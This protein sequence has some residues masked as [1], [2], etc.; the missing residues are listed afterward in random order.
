MNASRQQPSEPKRE[1][2]SSDGERQPPTNAASA[3]PAQI[4]TPASNGPAAASDAA[5]VAV[6]EVLAPLS[7]AIAEPSTER[8]RSP[9]TRADQLCDSEKTP[10]RKNEISPER[11][12]RHKHKHKGHSIEKKHKNSQLFEGWDTTQ[13]AQWLSSIGLYDIIPEEYGLTTFYYRLVVQIQLKIFL[14]LFQNTTITSSH[15]NIVIVCRNRVQIDGS[16]L[17]EL[18]TIKHESPSDFMKFL[19]DNFNFEA[20]SMAAIKFKAHLEK[21]T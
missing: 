20:T 13:T 15:S 16:F 18:R 3:A 10:T 21:L 5:P 4:Q 8:Q 17:K 11:K 2:N 6:A 9:Q 19:K 7:Q 14:R 1:K 12:S